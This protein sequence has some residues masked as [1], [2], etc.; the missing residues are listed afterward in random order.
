[1]SRSLTDN[2]PSPYKCSTHGCYMVRDTMYAKHPNGAGKWYHFFRCPRKGCKRMKADKWQKRRVQTQMTGNAHHDA[3]NVLLYGSQIPR[4][5]TT[6]F[7]MRAD[8]KR[9]SLTVP[10]ASATIAKI[11]SH[12]ITFGRTL[13]DHALDS[14][15]RLKRKE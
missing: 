3:T 1:M 10:D 4:N 9:P 12:A 2:Q 5:D 15:T 8:A 6:A 7:V 14:A 13:P 11:A